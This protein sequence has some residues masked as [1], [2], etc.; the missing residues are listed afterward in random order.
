M[1]KS[2]VEEITT[3]D[4]MCTPG[5]YILKVTD[6]LLA[7]KQRKDKK[8]I[9]SAVVLLVIPLGLFACGD[10]VGSFS[11]TE[12]SGETVVEVVATIRVRVLS[13]HRY[14]RYSSAMISGPVTNITSAV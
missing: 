9:L 6:V 5:G 14:H 3:P 2:R 1:P 10:G 7:Q 11:F 12:E 4:L 13:A 8:L